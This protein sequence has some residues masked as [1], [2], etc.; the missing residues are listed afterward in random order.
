MSTF[1]E[2]PDFYLNS[3]YDSDN[4]FVVG[5]APPMTH[6]DQDDICEYCGWCSAFPEGHICHAYSNAC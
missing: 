2:E 6:F 3:D 4:D 5:P 1:N